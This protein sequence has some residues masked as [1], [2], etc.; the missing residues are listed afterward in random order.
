M[1]CP[2]IHV[3]PNATTLCHQLE[4]GVVQIASP[5]LVSTFLESSE[6]SG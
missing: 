3:C 6:E 4:N 1:L 5:L 2:K